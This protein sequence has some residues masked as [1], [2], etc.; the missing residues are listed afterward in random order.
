MKKLLAVVAVG[1]AIMLPTPAHAS[2][3]SVSITCESTQ[4]GNRYHMPIFCDAYVS[5]G[6]G[7]Y[8]FNFHGTGNAWITSTYGASAGGQCNTGTWASVGVSVNDTWGNS[9]S[10]SAIF[11]CHPEAP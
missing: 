10:G 9:G 2:G 3:L 6:S 5:G 4:P 11:R 1:A 7:S 8:A